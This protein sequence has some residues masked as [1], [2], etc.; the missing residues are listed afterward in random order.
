MDA[1]SVILLEDII[2]IQRDA[3]RNEFWILNLEYQGL[4][5]PLPGSYESVEDIP[6]SRGEGI[7][8]YRWRL[9]TALQR[10]ENI[11]QSRYEEHGQ[12]E[13]TYLY[14]PQIC[15]CYLCIY[16]RTRYDTGRY[17]FYGREYY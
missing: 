9:V 16:N 14:N 7:V 3:R 12:Q 6:Y 11:Q 13:D 8:N 1:Q 2:Q 10:L 17:Y 4:D 15:H 5:P